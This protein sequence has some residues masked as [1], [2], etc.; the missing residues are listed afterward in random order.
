MMYTEQI[1][2]LERENN[3]QKLKHKLSMAK[4]KTQQQLIN[5]SMQIITQQMTMNTFALLSGMNSKGAN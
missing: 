5:S 4:H 1:L 3:A 2:K